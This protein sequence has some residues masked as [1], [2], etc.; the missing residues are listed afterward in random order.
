MKLVILKNLQVR[1]EITR[2]Q[3][4]LPLLENCG[5]FDFYSFPR[6]EFVGIEADNFCARFCV[7]VPQIINFVKNRQALFG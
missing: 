6:G 5:I 4:N 2:T 3:E 1:R 7:L